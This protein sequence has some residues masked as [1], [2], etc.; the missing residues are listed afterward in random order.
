MKLRSGYNIL[1]EG[2]PSK[3][4]EVPVDPKVLYLPLRSRRFTFSQVCVKEGQQVVA[5]EI[6]AE[7]PANYSVPLFALV[8]ERFVWKQL[9]TISFW[10]NSS[11]RVKKHV[12][13]AKIHRMCLKKRSR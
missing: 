4:V 10:K 3:E 1:L 6:L 7:D 9:K 2:K 12:V 11:S 8:V 13:H 5:G